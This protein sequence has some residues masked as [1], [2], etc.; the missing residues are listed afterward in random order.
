MTLPPVLHAARPILRD[1]LPT[2][3]FIA[4]LKLGWGPLVAT[5]IAMAIGVGQVGW[6]LARRRP[7]EALQGLSLVLV[8]VFGGATLVT[9]DPRFVMVKP[10]LVFAAVGATMLKPGWQSPYVPPIARPHLPDRA[11]RTWG[12]VWA[13]AMFGLAAGNAVVALA[14]PVEVWASVTAIAPMAT[15]ITLFALQY[16]TLRAGVA[17]AIREARDPAP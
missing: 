16:L 2:L 6:T 9:H 17:R 4:I 10:T 12:F 14:T 13:A 7:V 3:L 1:L 5:G 11:L 8:L 15:M